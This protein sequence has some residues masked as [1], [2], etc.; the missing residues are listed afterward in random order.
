MPESK[1]RRRRSR[2][3]GSGSRSD[4]DLSIARPRRRKTNYWYVAASTI[5]AVLVIG[6]FAI[7]GTNFGGRSGAAQ[8]GSNLTPVEG[9]GVVQTVVNFQHVPVG[10]AVDYSS[11]PPTS[12]DHWPPGEQASCG[13]YEDGLEDERAVHNLE[14]GN[15]VVSY[16]LSNERDI[17]ALRSALNTFAW[18][19]DWGVI[20]FYD[21]IPESMVVVA[22]WGRMVR[23][24]VFGLDG[25]AP[26]F[27]AYAGVLG[28]ER[29]AC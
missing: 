8:T 13:F 25:M 11:Y 4:R 7:G 3:G 16:N 20:R 1:S 15:I 10:E 22:A 29:I 21:K 14:H 24:P 6:G 5:I 19:E 2:Q 28:P 27:A 17:A 18:D 12:G 9:V 26:F 23:M